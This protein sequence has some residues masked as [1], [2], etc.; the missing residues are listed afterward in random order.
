MSEKVYPYLYAIVK[1]IDGQCS[2]G[3]PFVAYPHQLEGLIKN[4]LKGLEDSAFLE[5]YFV[6]LLAEYQYDS[7]GAISDVSDG[8]VPVDY[9]IPVKDFFLDPD[10]SDVVEEVTADVEA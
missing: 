5:D 9:L 6:E 8:D 7:F 2:Y 10:K 1:H 4:S 3:Q